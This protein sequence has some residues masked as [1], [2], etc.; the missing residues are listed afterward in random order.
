MTK[1]AFTPARLL[2][3][4][5]LALATP[6]AAQELPVS[7]GNY[8]DVSAIDVVDGQDAA[9]IDYL[10]TTWKR[11]QEFARSKGYID[12]YHVLTN[13]YARA[14]EPDLYLVTIY[15]KWYDTAEQERQRK[16]Y[17]AMMQRDQR[18]L[19]AESGGRATMRKLAGSML[20]REWMFK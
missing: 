6:A 20:L 8:W 11:S 18:K 3:S 1:R 19:M 12:G 5:I 16:E 13:E 2:L 14:G 9:Y 4:A 15:K 10:A 17:E 7:P